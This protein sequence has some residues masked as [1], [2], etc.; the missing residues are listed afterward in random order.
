MEDKCHRNKVMGHNGT[1]EQRFSKVS[2]FKK[3]HIF[4]SRLW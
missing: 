3:Q 2:A 1:L 4:L